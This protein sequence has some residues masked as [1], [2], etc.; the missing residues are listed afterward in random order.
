MV[1][2]VRA[3]TT[4]NRRKGALFRLKLSVFRWNKNPTRRFS[5]VWMSELAFNPIVPGLG[6]RPGRPGSS[7]RLLCRRTETL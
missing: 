6:I 1:S 7:K 5:P 4:G 2:A 3:L